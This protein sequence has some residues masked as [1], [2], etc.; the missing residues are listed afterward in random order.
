MLMETMTIA[1]SYKPDLKGNS[2]NNTPMEKETG[3]REAQEEEAD[4][5]DGE[6]GAEE[7]EEEVAGVE[8]VEGEVEVGGEGEDEGEEEEV[9]L[10]DQ[11]EPNEPELQ[12][13]NL[14][15]CFQDV[16]VDFHG[17]KQETKAGELFYIMMIQIMTTLCPLRIL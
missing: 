2:E 4:G 13:M 17:L 8:G 1:N 7:A 12:M 14:I 16:S 3:R 9:P 5:E 15:R 11:A 10:E 6:D